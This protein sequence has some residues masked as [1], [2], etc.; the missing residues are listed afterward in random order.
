MSRNHPTVQRLNRAHFVLGTVSKLKLH[1]SII[2]DRQKLQEA[3]AQYFGEQ[4]AKFEWRGLFSTEQLYL[5]I[6][7]GETVLMIN[8]GFRVGY[9]EADEIY[10]GNGTTMGVD[11]VK[12][13]YGVF[14][15]NEDQLMDDTWF[16]NFYRAMAT[17][18]PTIPDEYPL[19][20]YFPIH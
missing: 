10:G 6:E 13:P 3:F 11:M 14:I 2:Y 17:V 16:E 5:S 7:L 9:D 1:P 15:Q 12:T 19:N 20:L 4:P 18:V 8:K